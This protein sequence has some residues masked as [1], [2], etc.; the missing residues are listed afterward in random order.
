MAAPM[1]R[2][3]CK[4]SRNF[5]ASVNKT[6]NNALFLSATRQ[7][8]SLKA[9]REIHINA[10]RISASIISKPCRTFSTLQPSRRFSS[11]SEGDYSRK[12]SLKLMDFPLIYKLSWSSPMTMVRNWLFTLLIRGY[13]DQEFTWANFQ[14]GAVEVDFLVRVDLFLKNSPHD[15]FQPLKPLS[16]FVVH[17]LDTFK[18]S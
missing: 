17:S 1:L 8:Q 12:R 4:S 5:L 13:F 18:A 14:Q 3:G 6:R 10:R 9:V 16:V 11:D 15:F 2:W 7:R